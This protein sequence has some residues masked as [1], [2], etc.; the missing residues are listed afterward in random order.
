M[1]RLISKSFS[2]NDQQWCHNVTIAM[3]HCYNGVTIGGNQP[4]KNVCIYDVNMQMILK[5]LPTMTS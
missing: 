1:R 2:N 4:I 3:V 5:Q